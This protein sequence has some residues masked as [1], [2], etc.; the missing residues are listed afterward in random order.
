MNQ[1]EEDLSGAAAAAAAG[2][3]L[4]FRRWTEGCGRVEN[5]LMISHTLELCVSD[6][7]M[8]LCGLRPAV[9]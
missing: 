5:L 2:G 8:K 3:S 9:T 1:P 6:L 7:Y 4:R